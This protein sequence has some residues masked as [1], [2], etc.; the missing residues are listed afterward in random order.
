MFQSLMLCYGKAPAQI[1]MELIEEI[2]KELSVENAN[3]CVLG[4]NVG[5]AEKDSGIETIKEG[6]AGMAG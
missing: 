3:M 5:L 2:L 1:E 4:Q 6:V